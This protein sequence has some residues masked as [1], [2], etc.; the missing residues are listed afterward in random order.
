MWWE[1]GIVNG[2]CYSP[3]L[4]SICHGRIWI[5]FTAI[6]I[7]FRIGVT[8]SLEN[9]LCVYNSDVTV[10]LLYPG[11]KECKTSA[12]PGGNRLNNDVW[13]RKERNFTHT[14]S[15]KLFLLKTPAGNSVNWLSCKFLAT[16]NHNKL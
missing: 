14:L 13:L 9:V 15:S 4:W 1:L 8:I 10:Q 16:N 5:D 12:L 2:G 11:Q 3:L 6:F 7:P